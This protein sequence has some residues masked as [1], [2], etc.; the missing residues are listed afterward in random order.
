MPPSAIDRGIH[1]APPDEA[2]LATVNGNVDGVGLGVVVV[3][4]TGRDLAEEFPLGLPVT[5]H[6]HKAAL[7]PFSDNDPVDLM[8]INR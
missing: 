1:P 7:I 6:V 4:H 2:G 8:P 3:Q 5:G